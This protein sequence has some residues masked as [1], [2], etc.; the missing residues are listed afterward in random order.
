MATTSINLPAAKKLLSPEGMVPPRAAFL[1]TA[2]TSNNPLAAVQL[3][4]RQGRPS[5]VV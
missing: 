2:T 5:A 1:C 3:W 4:C